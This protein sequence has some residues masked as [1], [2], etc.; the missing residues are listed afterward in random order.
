VVLPAE[1]A[2]FI[3]VMPAEGGSLKTLEDT[4][5][6]KPDFL[7][8]QLERRLGDVELPEFD[9]RSDNYLRSHLEDL[10]VE[11]IFRD[12]GDL[13]K[14]PGTLLLGVKQAVSFKIDRTGIQA[15]AKTTTWG[16]LGALVSEDEKFHMKVDR[17]FLFQVRDNMT[18]V[19]LFM[20]AV[21]DPSRH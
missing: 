7:E 3:V 1:N 10:G 8:S 20:G 9:F 12:L 13:S 6:E 15:E 14:V 17:P 16:V 21:S 5:A 19:L 18:G 11:T 4:F 2:D